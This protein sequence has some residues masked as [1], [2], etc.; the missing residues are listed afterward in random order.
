MANPPVFV[1]PPAA[2]KATSQRTAFND[3]INAHPTMRGYADTI[4]K[5]AKVYGVDPVVMAGLYWR[6]SFAAA[7]ASGQDPASI[8]SP[9]GAGVGIGQINPKVHVGEK[10]PWGATIT[11]SDLVDPEFNIRWS[12]WYFSQQEAKYGNPDDAY[13]KG[14]NPG[15]AGP[16]LS[17]LLPKGYVPSAG[18]SPTQA[19]SV[20]VEKKVAKQT[21]TDPWV[22]LEPNGK[23][24]MVNATEPP[25]GTLTYGAQPLT[26]SNFN[27]V[28]KQTYADT[29]YAYTGRAAKPAEIKQILNDAVTPYALAN[30]LAGQKSFVQSP[31]YKSRAPGIAEIAKQML[32]KAPPAALVS[33]A[34]AQNWDQATLQANIMKLPAYQTGPDFKAKTATIQTVYNQIYGNASKSGTEWIKAAAL[35]GWTQDQAATAL[36][37]DPAYK[38]SPEYQSKAVNFLDAMGL[39]TG[40]RP[41]ASV[42]NKTVIQQ[43]TQ[44][45]KITAPLNLQVGMGSQ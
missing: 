1:V 39:F 4:Q 36:R 10:T 5:Y 40:S 26:E 30:Q 3:F 44:P 25:K 17:S 8:T 15:Y 2:P 28:W 23:I 21:I 16:A 24:R 35:N 11:Q 37:A 45:S 19:A 18:L 34:I 13:D 33:Q 27:S 31:T 22:V 43:A 9:T 12:T 42:Q 38:Y 29:F 7:K 32:G 6:E 41:V 14:Y 20:A